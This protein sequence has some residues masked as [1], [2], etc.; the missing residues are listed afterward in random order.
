MRFVGP[1]LPHPLRASHCCSDRSTLQ[2]YSLGSHLT[3][4]KCG[5]A[6]HPAMLI[7]LCGC[8]AKWRMLQP[9][10]EYKCGGSSLQFACGHLRLPG[11]GLVCT[12]ILTRAN[13]LLGVGPVDIIRSISDHP[14]FNALMAGRQ[15]EPALQHCAA[16]PTKAV[17]V[18]VPNHTLPT[19]RVNV[20]SEST[21]TDMFSSVHVEESNEITS[22]S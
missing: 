17:L 21:A 19:M 15:A 14:L 9:R 8:V 5:M 3:W 4:C 1:A 13:N 20:R 7:L 22:R 16:P 18:W 2:S 11:A 12:C 6:R 10:L